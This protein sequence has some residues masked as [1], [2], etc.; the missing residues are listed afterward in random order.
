MAGSE[1][2]PD[3]L[4]VARMRWRAAEDRLYPQ[5][6][7]DPDAY[8]RVVELV[9]AVLGEL[10]RHTRT[11][12]DLAAVESQADAVLGALAAQRSAAAVVSGEL[13]VQAACA[14]RCRELLASTGEAIHQERHA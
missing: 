8:Q 11:V 5:L 6:I 9:G 13:L 2:G 14:L 1:T 4:A 12:E 10:R 3:R 7:G